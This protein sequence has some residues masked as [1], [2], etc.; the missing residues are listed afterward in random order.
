MTDELIHAIRQIPREQLNSWGKDSAVLFGKITWRRAKNFGKLVE[1]ICRGTASEVTSGYNA[2]RTGS[3]VNHAKGRANAAKDSIYS[4]GAAIAASAK[5]IQ[6]ALQSNPRENAPALV[7]S[8]LAFLVASGGG[9]GDGGVPDLDLLAGIDAHRS[10]FTHSIVSAAAIETFLL[11]SASFVSLAHSFLPERHD[12]IWDS[13]A[14]HKDRYV[15]ATSQG[16]SLGI[17]YHLFV[18]S[19]VDIGAYHD[20]PVSLPIEGHEAIAGANAAAEAIDVK[21]KDQKRHG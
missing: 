5:K 7:V 20:L 10:I 11:S 6:Y 15:L 2:H 1:R 8:T 19:T 9:D 18:D 3:F 16:A 21:H 17:A 4:T 13:I 12:P 14:K